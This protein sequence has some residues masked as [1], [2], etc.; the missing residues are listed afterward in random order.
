MKKRAAES[1]KPSSTPAS[2]R[3]DVRDSRA[4][5]R[6]EAAEYEKKGTSLLE[7]RSVTRNVEAGYTQKY[8]DFVDW[9]SKTD[10]P[11]ESLAERDESL[12][13]Y[14]THMFLE[15]YSA[16]DFSKA[17]AAAAFFW[18]DV[19]RAGRDLLRASKAQRGFAKLA[20]ASPRVPAPWI[21]VA[22]V[23]SELAVRGHWEWAMT[24]LV[25]FMGYLRP[26]GGHLCAPVKG[27][28]PSHGLRSLLLHPSEGRTRSN[29][30]ETDQCV[31][32]SIRSS[33]TSCRCCASGRM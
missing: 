26:L 19:S 17:R 20:P 15:G 5:H 4:H 22:H 9:A 10:R 2:R 16:A 13:L 3:A 32:S 28:G 21:M 8:N 33:R 14:G 7:A 25:L 23:A 12:A 27:A 1:P 31:T 18:K 29:I 6:A 30:G 24:V 11:L